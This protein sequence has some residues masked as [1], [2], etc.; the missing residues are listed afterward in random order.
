MYDSLTWKCTKICIADL[1]TDEIRGETKELC[2]MLSAATNNLAPGSFEIDYAE[3]GH[4][5]ID[6]TETRS[7]C[8]KFSRR[9]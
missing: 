5:W 6:G 1:K 2:T 8:V 7:C 9:R 4:A 3:V